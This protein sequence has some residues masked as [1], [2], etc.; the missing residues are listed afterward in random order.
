MPDSTIKELVS[1]SGLAFTGTVESTGLAGASGLPDD[2]RMAVVR[3][4]QVLH[5]PKQLVLSVGTKVI[6]QMAPD[7]PPL[8]RG[9]QAT[10]FANGLAYGD[11][12]AVAEVG[13]LPLGAGATIKS[14][15][16]AVPAVTAVQ[17]ARAELAQ[18][19]VADHA[20]QV[21]AVVRGHVS[22]LVEAPQTGPPGEHDPQWW[23]ATLR[24]DLVPRGNV[25]QPPDWQP[26]DGQLE[27]VV[28]YAN[29]LDVQWRHWPKPKA[30]QGQL[31]LLHRTPEERAELA[32]FEL[33]HRIDL[34][35][36]LELDLLRKRGM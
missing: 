35:P 21:A 27:V 14:V 5:A 9:E 30:G 34:Q 33:R 12:L 10:F 28:L 13:R 23:T 7:Q 8:G 19:R 3:V 17:A 6:L 32:S 31:W 11:D 18:D 16:G 25:G 20:S 24:V 2:D 4:E 22:A 15:G 36:S 26:S 29:S 1:S